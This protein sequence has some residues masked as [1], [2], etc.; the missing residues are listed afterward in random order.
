MN[1]PIEEEIIEK[2]RVGMD[3]GI[4]YLKRMIRQ[5]GSLKI[6]TKV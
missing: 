1:K 5:N 6:I 3:N 4:A 2:P